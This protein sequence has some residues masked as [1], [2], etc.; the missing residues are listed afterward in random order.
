MAVNVNTDT[1]VISG[2]SDRSIN[3]WRNRNSKI[4]RPTD[5]TITK[6][7]QTNKI[8]KQW[9]KLQYSDN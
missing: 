1:Y 5:S 2:Y 4:C 7:Q 9:S 3:V 8:K 6:K